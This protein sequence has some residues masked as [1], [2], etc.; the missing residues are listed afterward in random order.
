M[1]ILFKPWSD[2]SDL[3]QNGNATDVECALKEAFNE[4][5]QAHP[6]VAKYLANMQALHYESKFILELVYIVSVSCEIFKIHG[7]QR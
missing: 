3:I 4:M 2:P 5:V 1:L 7:R 6:Q